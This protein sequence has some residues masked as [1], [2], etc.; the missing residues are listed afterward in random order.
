MK[1]IKDSDCAQNSPITYGYP[2]TSIYRAGQ[3]IKPKYPGKQE[4]DYEKKIFLPEL[5]PLEEYDLII[6]LF[7]GGKDSVAAYFRLLE[8]GVPKEKIELWHHDIDGGHPNWL[9]PE[10]MG[11]VLVDTAL[12]NNSKSTTGVSRIKSRRDEDSGAAKPPSEEEE[13]S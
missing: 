7:S 11:K 12:E 13:E 6:V 4:T 10:D 8:L 5:L 1:V 2:E 3:A 9:G